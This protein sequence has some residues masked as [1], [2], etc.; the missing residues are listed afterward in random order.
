[1]LQ[2]S[3]RFSTFAGRPAAYLDDVF[4]WPAE[5]G[6]GVVDALFQEA[7]RRAVARG[8]V[9]IALDVDAVNRRA[10]RAY[11]RLGFRD[12]GADLLSKALTPG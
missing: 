8:C 10:R 1:M 4:V 9:R 2:V 11:E 12:S 6:R 5:R 3:Y 7:E